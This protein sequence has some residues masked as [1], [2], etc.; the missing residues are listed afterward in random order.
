VFACELMRPWEFDS[1][2]PCRTIMLP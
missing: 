1:S 2:F